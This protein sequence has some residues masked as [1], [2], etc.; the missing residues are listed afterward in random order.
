M[1]ASKVEPFS[2]PHAR[3]ET[4]PRDMN[5]VDPSQD[6]IMSLAQKFD[7]VTIEI[8]QTQA[9]LLNKVTILERERGQQQNFPPRPQYNNNVNLEEIK[10]GI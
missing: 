8:M 2:A 10:G 7:K 3:E 9:T 5:N 1:L 4:K 6:P